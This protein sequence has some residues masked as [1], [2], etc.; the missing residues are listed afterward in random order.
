M[1]RINLNE[2]TA[3]L[4]IDQGGSGA[5]ILIPRSGEGVREIRF[6]DDPFKIADEL[7]LLA[8][9]HRLFILIEYTHGRRG[10]DPGTAYTFGRNAGRVEGMMLTHGMKWD[11][12]R[13]EDWKAK[14]DLLGYE[15]SEGKRKARD[16]AKGL[17][18]G[19]EPILETGDAYL[20]A[21]LAWMNLIGEMN[22]ETFS[23]IVHD[24]SMLYSSA[25]ST[26]AK[27]KRKYGKPGGAPRK[28][29]KRFT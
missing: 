3:A 26:I 8:L 24:D 20:I 2:C 21:W 18:K 7:S 12:I 6:S 4:G 14:F 22:Y 19:S 1:T 23:D 9:E 10:D 27:Y 13:D 5:G 17:F 11:Y 16:K 29:S 28:R 15:Y 25:R